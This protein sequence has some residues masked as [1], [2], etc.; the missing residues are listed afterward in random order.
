VSIKRKPSAKSP[1]RKKSSLGEN[2]NRKDK[3]ASPVT[4]SGKKKKKKASTLE[5]YFNE[6]EGKE[7]KPKVWNLTP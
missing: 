1:R 5:Q 6:K 7:V 4:K 3:T 2:P